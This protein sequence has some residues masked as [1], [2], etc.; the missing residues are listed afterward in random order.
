MV[1]FVSFQAGP[2]LGDLAAAAPRVT[3][4]GR[5]SCLRR[6]ALSG[7]SVDMQARSMQINQS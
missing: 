2:F 7:S 6:R 5:L 1:S 3:T 4:S